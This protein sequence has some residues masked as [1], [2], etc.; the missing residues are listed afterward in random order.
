MAEHVLVSGAG[1][2]C[3]G[4]YKPLY[5]AKTGFDRV[6]MLDDNYRLYYNN[7]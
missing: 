5:E 3:N 7:G 6:W 1:F 2:N 4:E